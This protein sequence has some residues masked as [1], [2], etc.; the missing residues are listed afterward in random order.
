MIEIPALAAV[1]LLGS[2]NMFSNRMRVF[3]NVPRHT[4]LS[5]ASG[6]AVAFVLLQLLPSISKGQEALSQATQT[7]V[8]SFLERHAY[9]LMLVSVLV[10]YGLEKAARVSSTSRPQEKGSTPGPAVF[11][12]HMITF[13]VMNILVGYLM[14]H[15]H[16]TL[17]ALLLF[18]LAM[19]VKFIINDNSLHASHKEGYDRIGRWLL[20]GAVVF[21]WAVGY[22]FKL[23]NV[24]PAMLQALLAGAVLLNVFKEELPSEKQ[25]KL[26]PFALGAAA[27]AALLMVL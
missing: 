4:F 18:S 22:V 24:G 10:F 12:L 17:Q 25:G 3:E 15:R 14:I 19:F 13:G 27:Y 16:E 6:A 21:G 9:L 26:L 20:A 8:F 11:W 5:A 1:L 2:V 7:G 23:P